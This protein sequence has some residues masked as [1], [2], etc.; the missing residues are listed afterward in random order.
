MKL[1]Y[2]WRQWA[3]V[4]DMNGD[5]KVTISDVLLWGKWLYFYPGDIFVNLLI[6]IKPIREFFE[7]SSDNYGGAFSGGIS[8]VSWLVCCGMLSAICND[9]NNA[10]AKK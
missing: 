7:L 1:D 4:A 3:F 8:F 5:S 6:G 9:I 10:L 2:G